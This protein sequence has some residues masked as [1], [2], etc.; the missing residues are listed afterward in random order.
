M[1]SALIDKK[2][3]RFNYQTVEHMDVMTSNNMMEGDAMYGDVVMW[4]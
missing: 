2:P 4:Y 1:H 3:S